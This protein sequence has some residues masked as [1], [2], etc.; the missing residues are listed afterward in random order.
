MTASILTVLGVAKLL[1]K[2]L[3]KAT[4]LRKAPAEVA[5]LLEDLRGLCSILENIVTHLESTRDARQFRNISVLGQHVAKADQ[6]VKEIDLLTNTSRLSRLNFSDKNA[7]RVAWLQNRSK[8][9]SL[10]ERLHAVK[11]NLSLAFDSLHA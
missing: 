8:I 6:L 5:H 1:V 7:K 3:D 10:E 11:T 9:K 4:D 2:G